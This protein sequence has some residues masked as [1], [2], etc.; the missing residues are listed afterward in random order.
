MP[1][2]SGFRET[3][4]WFQESVVLPHEPGRDVRLAPAESVILPSST[5]K[6]E[7][8]MTIYAEAYMAR[9]V[10]ALEQD[11]PAVLK[12]IGHRAFHSMCREYLERFPSRSWSLNP[13]GRRLPEFLSDHSS[14]PER[15]AVRDLA[16]VEIAM[17]EV[18]DAEAGTALTPADFRKLPLK[19]LPFTRLA[20]VPT[21]RL[22]SLGH[23]VNPFIDAVRQERRTI[24]P[25]PKKPSW[26]AIY[27]SGF[28]VV[29]LDIQEPAFACLWALLCGATVAGAVAAAE[30]LWRGKPSNL[31][32][33]IRQWFGE[34]VSRGFFA[35]IDQKK[36][37]RVGHCTKT[38]S[39]PRRFGTPVRN[40]AFFD[41]T[42]V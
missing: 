4:R 13:L 37:G 32:Q 21:F 42:L 15:E 2:P 39:R 27:R 7:A 14:V 30:M 38:N 8:R 35:G 10:E 40:R 18:F 3:I 22:L 29:R 19:K 34:W 16:S 12:L 5:L 31:E 26:V 28:R 23:S 20:F 33:Q 11:F 9:L 1:G 24:P 36:G 6:P 25:I 41:P 17:S